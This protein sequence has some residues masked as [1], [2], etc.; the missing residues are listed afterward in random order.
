[1]SS[2]FA[3]QSMP[4]MLDLTVVPLCRLTL[5]LAVSH[6]FAMQL[7]VRLVIV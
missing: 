5:I 6:S 2:A 4:V 7:T 1:M 3:T